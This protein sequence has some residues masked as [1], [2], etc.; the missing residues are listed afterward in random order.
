MRVN[1]IYTE[2]VNDALFN[3][4]SEDAEILLTRVEGII[5]I[6]V[7]NDRLIVPPLKPTISIYAID[8]YKDMVKMLL[9]M[10]GK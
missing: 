2:C 5:N 9:E 7:S 4:I 6:V 1:L 8:R 10:L 3:Y